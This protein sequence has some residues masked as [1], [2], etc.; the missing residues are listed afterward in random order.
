MC[1]FISFWFLLLL[2][3]KQ[4]IFSWTWPV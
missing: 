3:Y 1:S 4:F 2:A